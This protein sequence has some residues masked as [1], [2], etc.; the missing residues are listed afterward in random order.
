MGALKDVPR[1]RKWLTAAGY[2]AG[3][4]AC[5]F[6]ATYNFRLSPQSNLHNIRYQFLMWSGQRQPYYSIWSEPNASQQELLRS[7]GA[8]DWQP[9]SVTPRPNQLAG[10]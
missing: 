8:L 10:G 6:L 7:N 2:V 4:A 9:G 3:L 1:G 5:V